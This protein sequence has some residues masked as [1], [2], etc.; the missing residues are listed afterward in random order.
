MVLPIKKT[1]IPCQHFCSRWEIFLFSICMFNVSAKMQ[2]CNCGWLRVV[3]I[4]S[5]T[6]RI[7]WSVC[8]LNYN[9]EGLKFWKI[10]SDMVSFCN[11]YDWGPIPVLDICSHYRN[12][13]HFQ[14][15]VLRPW[16]YIWLNL[17]LLFAIALL[18]HIAYKSRRRGRKHLV[19]K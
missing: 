11:W 4:I 9:V 16:W 1:A 10:Y 8:E 12:F 17:N 14:Q 18:F 7:K 15:C 6:I 5:L 19:K 3:T 13:F 2:F